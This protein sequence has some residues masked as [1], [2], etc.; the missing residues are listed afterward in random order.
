MMVSWISMFISLYG[1]WIT[2]EE[3]DITTVVGCSKR[4]NIIRYSFLV[5]SFGFIT[6]FVN[7][8]WMDNDQLVAALAC[9]DAF[10]KGILTIYSLD[11][12]L[13]RLL[14]ME[15]QLMVELEAN[16]RRRD[17]MKYVSN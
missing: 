17:F 5:A 4:D 9:M 3:K 10:T 14:A 7:V 8:G 15:G 13:V 16:T 6:L 11:S 2:V 1:I 12:Q